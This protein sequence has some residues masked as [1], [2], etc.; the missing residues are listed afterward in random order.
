MRPEE[1][2]RAVPVP[3]V[4]DER[5][6]NAREL[7][8]VEIQVRE[9]EAFATAKVKLGFV[10]SQNPERKRDLDQPFL[11]GIPREESKVFGPARRGRKFAERTRHGGPLLVVELV[12]GTLIRKGRLNRVEGSNGLGARRS[13][14]ADVTADEVD[15]GAG[16]RNEADQAHAARAHHDPHPR[17]A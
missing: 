13:F 11:L 17:P 12:E 14:G 7:F 10:H 2:T 15:A 9:V 5:W 16:N 1:D 6:A 3:I 4:E 8:T